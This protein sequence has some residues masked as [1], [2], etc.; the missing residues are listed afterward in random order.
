MSLVLD[1]YD[2]CV[3]DVYLLILSVFTLNN[4]YNINLFQE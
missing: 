2:R 4:S 1:R 3:Y